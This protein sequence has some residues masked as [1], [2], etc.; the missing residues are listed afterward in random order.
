MN[1]TLLFESVKAELNRQYERAVEALTGAREAAT[2][3]DT[4]A[5]NK[6]DTRGL[7][8][9]YLAAGQADQADEILR[10]MA[11]L[12]A[13][14]V[15][16]FDFDDPIDTGAVV[17]VEKDDE[18]SFY[19]IAPAGGGLIVSSDTG[20]TITVLGPGSPLSRI[21]IGKTAGTILSD[22][23]LMILEVL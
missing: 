14:V 15:K 8:A 12:E 20:E 17:E 19:L 10:A 3:T 9:S 11:S 23:D 13:F 4:R 5:E 16:D 22:P 6:Y 2:G 1:K 7:E 21:L 18:I